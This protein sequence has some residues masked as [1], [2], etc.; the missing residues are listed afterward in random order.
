MI[1][2]NEIANTFIPNCK[3]GEIS[4][5]I[6]NYD[7]IPIHLR[8]IYHEPLE[9]VVGVVMLEH[10]LVQLFFRD[11]LNFNGFSFH[12]IDNNGQD[13]ISNI[14]QGFFRSSPS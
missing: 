2:S 10:N 9:V 4:L 5:P 8:T 1:E 6:N 12:I 7:N 13:I 3:D 14:I 11:T